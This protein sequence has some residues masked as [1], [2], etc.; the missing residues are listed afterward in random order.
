MWPGR[1]QT[2][3]RSSRDSARDLAETLDLAPVMVRD[4][5][6]TVRSWGTSL[7]ELYGYPG[8]EAI[9]HRSHELL[10][11]VFPKP[12]GEIEAEL[13]RN[14]RW[15]GELRHRHK[16]GSEIIVAS[17]WTLRRDRSGEIRAVVEVNNDVTEARRAEWERLRLAAIVECSDDAIVAK[18]LDGTV[19]SWNPAAER[20]L[21]YSAAEII[22][23][24]ISVLA[25]PGLENDMPRILE[26]IRRGEVVDHYE[27][28]RRRKD[29]T[30]ID[31]SVTVSP[32]RDASGTIT[33][34]SK[35][36]RDITQQKQSQA[37][38]REAET[39]F[40]SI[41]EQAA[42]GIAEV[43]LDG[44]W[45]A[46]NQRLCEITG[47][48]HKDLLRLSFQD[49]THPDDLELDLTCVADCSQARMT[50][51]NSRSATSPGRARRC[52]LS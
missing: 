23:R 43:A 26:R 1:K 51:I 50:A 30:V 33:G 21:G 17:F 40:R 38:L 5:D 34:A 19:T 6:G 28:R 42:V 12:L 24:K 2:P 14:G 7:C 11:T 3:P 41:F 44:R 27:T 36:A 8:T 4:L 46:V 35:I 32:I 16:D 49:I 48:G 29:G 20:M 37:A 9:G 39:R 52:G 22:G 13:L 25:P 47:Y 31:V 18:D 10:R 15:R 45:I